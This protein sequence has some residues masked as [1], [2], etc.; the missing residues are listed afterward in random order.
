M[1]PVISF[2]TGTYNRL[3]MLQALFASIRSQMPKGIAYDFVVCDGGSTDGTLDWLRTQT[4]VTL[5]EDGK[6]VGAISAFTRAAFAATGKYVMLMNDDIEFKPASILPAIVHLE[7]HDTCGAVAFRDNRPIPGAYTT[8]DYKTLRMPATVKGKQD[9]VIYAQVG[10]FRKWLGDVCHWWMGEH[11]EMAGA[12][13][14]AGDNTL[15][16]HIWGHGYSVDEIPACTVEDRVAEDELRVVNR[17]I[18]R[19]VDDSSFYYNQWMGLWKGPIVP[20]FPD[21]IQHDKRSARILYL[22]IYDPGWSVAKDP[23]VGKKGLREALQRAVNK[24]GEPHLVYEVDYLGLA[25]QELKSTLMQIGETFRPDLIL[26]Q[27][28][29]PKPIT[30]DILADLKAVTRAPVVNWNG[31]QAV[32]GLMSAEIMA[33]LRYVDL[34]LMV[35]TDV[36]EYY[37]KMGVNYA[38]WQI[39]CEEPGDNL[40]GQLSDYFN[41]TGRENPY[42]SYPVYPIAFLASLYTPARQAIASIV[43]EFGGLVASPGDMW[44]TLYNF[45]A[46]KFI[47][48]HAKIAIANNDYPDSYGFVSNRMMQALAAGGALLLQQPVKGLQQL[49]GIT[50]GVH[51]VEYTTLDDL[52]EKLA[53]WTHPEHE[54]ERKMIVETARDYMAKYHSFDARVVELFEIIRRKLGANKQLAESVELR[55]KGRMQEPFGAGKGAVT[56]IQYQYQPGHTLLVHKN[57]IEQFLLVPELWEIAEKETA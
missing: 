28:Q 7:R 41:R 16:A 35:S 6:L 47:Y 53:Y 42:T 34:Q 37:D 13:T 27:L 4:D 40:E 49:T 23:V 5:I 55:Y 43:R 46:G 9:Y 17:E 48:Q 56:G 52:K 19:T 20:D 33:V 2:V 22:P 1:R 51:Y 57:D 15:S 45:T 18:G 12:Y 26:T 30:A 14:Y 29:S 36:T 3:P 50:A 11:D 21:I 32:G 54:I 25:P 44:D 39:G 24:H 8:K 38:Y 31:D 10:L